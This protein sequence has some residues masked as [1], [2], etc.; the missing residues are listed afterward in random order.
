[1]KKALTACRS[2]V[3][4][5][6][7]LPSPGFFSP[8]PH[9]TSALSVAVSYLALEGGPPRFRRVSRAPPYSGTSHGADQFF[10][11]GAFTLSGRPSQCLPLSINE[12]SNS[13]AHMHPPGALQPPRANGA[14]L[15]HA[16]FGL[17]PVRSPL[18]EGIS[19]DFFSSRYLDGSVPW[20]SLHVPYFIQAW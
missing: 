19:I 18:L 15:T 14:R 9:G 20:V 5:S 1:M 10:V 3:S 8:F 16:W 11:Y 6:I 7:S 4:G 12:V 17:F 13:T 2:T